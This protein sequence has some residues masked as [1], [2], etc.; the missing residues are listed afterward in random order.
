[1][2]GLRR[3]GARTVA[4]SGPFKSPSQS[5][6][7]RVGR[8]G[9]A[10]HTSTINE[11][12]ANRRRLASSQREV[13]LHLRLNFD[14]FAV[15]QVALVFP[16]LYSLDRSRSQHRMPADQ[17]QVL[18]V[19]CLADLRLQQHR[20]LNTSLTGQRRIR[21]RNLANQKTRSYT[22]RYTHALRSSDLRRH[23]WSCAQDAAHDATH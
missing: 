22:C 8:G 18:D 15:Q 12:Y 19:A 3:N 14:W 20:A 1:M 2:H 10:M 4:K 11:N 17:L 5:P 7:L 6:T 9:L 23:R 13:H 16:L 21:R